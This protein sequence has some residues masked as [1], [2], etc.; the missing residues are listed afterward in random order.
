MTIIAPFDSVAATQ[1]RMPL[2]LPAALPSQ[3]ATITP[4][5]STASDANSLRLGYLPS[6]EHHQHR[7]HHRQRRPALC[8]AT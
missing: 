8:A 7:C 5:D 4:A 2:G 1:S 3:T 6:Y